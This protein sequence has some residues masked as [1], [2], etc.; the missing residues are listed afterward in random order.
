MSEHA[1]ANLSPVSVEKSSPGKLPKS[2]VAVIATLL[3][4]TFVVILNETIMNV[5]LSHLMKDLNVSSTTVQWLATGFML[6]MAVVIPT[7]GF[8]LEKITTRQAFTIAMTLFLAGTALAAAAPGFG[9]L[10]LARVIQASGTALMMPLL[11]TTI[12][13]LV[14]IGRRGVVMGNVSIAI[15]VAPA[16]GPTVSGFILEH[17]SWRF[18]FIFVLPIAIAALA[19]GLKFLQNVNKPGDQQ[20]D[21]LSVFLTIPAFGGIVY[22]LSQLGVP[23]PEGVN[24]KAIVALLIGLATMTIFVL[25]QLSLQRTSSPLLD[26]RVF[27]YAMFRTSTLLMVVAMI[28]MFGAILLIPLYLQTILMVDPQTTGLILLPG[29]LIMGLTGPLIGRLFDKVG[30]LP[31]TIT[32][33]IIITLCLLAYSQLTLTTPLLWIAAVQTCLN[34]GLALIFTPSF[35]TALNPLPPELYSH[36]SAGVATLQQVAGAAGTAL[37]VAIYTIVASGSDLLTGM[38]AAFLTAACVA[39]VA[40]VLSTMMRKTNT[41]APAHH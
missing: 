13:T 5:A 36:G 24:W 10:L 33:S 26:L 34:L 31:L 12:L 22:G 23:E 9:V 41:E 6:T 35:T 15:S 4:A 21:L 19:V 14:P 25:R 29:G 8:I 30:P 11:M 32:G 17:Y 28:A 20:L 40:I 16:L 2:S 39:V 37:L 3:V 27:K 18:L 7:T 38:R 1:A